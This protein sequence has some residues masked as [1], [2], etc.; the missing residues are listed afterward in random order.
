[1]LLKILQI[2]TVS[3]LFIFLV[4]HL[5]QFLTATLTVPKIKDLV[6]APK[7]TYSHIYETLHQSSNS[8]GTT[9]IDLL[10]SGSSSSSSSSTLITDTED[11]KNE[12]KHF[13]KSQL[14]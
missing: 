1:M 12:L 5:L 7:Q 10:P 9:S 14:N 3:I 11:M 4:H 2:S 8:S 13:L 6:N